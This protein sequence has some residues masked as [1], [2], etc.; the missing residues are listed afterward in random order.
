MCEKRR[1]VVE[2]VR[3]E[4]GRCGCLL[5]GVACRGALL[6]GKVGYRKEEGGVDE[7]TKKEKKRPRGD[8]R[9]IYIMHHHPVRASPDRETQAKAKRAATERGVETLGIVFV[10][11]YLDWVGACF[12]TGFLPFPIIDEHEG[13]LH[14]STSTSL[15]HILD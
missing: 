8:V 4:C 6:A 13:V 1:W 14:P 3:E 11:L 5:G 2:V 15:V 9:G 7:G 12:L 10:C